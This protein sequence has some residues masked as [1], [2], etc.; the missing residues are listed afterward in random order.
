MSKFYCKIMIIIITVTQNVLKIC[1]SY[2]NILVL[3][4][5]YKSKSY[6]V[7]E[8]SIT[9]ACLLIYLQHWELL[10]CNHKAYSLITEKKQDKQ[11]K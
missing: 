9:T 6:Y 8:I 2:S 10:L 3:S 5:K 1:S 11:N 4:L 7:I